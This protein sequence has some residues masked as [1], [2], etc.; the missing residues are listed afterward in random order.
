MQYAG[1]F[2]TFAM[3]F[4]LLTITTGMVRFVTGAPEHYQLNHNAWR[5]CAWCEMILLVVLM[6]IKQQN[7]EFLYGVI[8]DGV[9]GM[10]FLVI[11]IIS[12][13]GEYS[14]RMKS[15]RQT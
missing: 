7:R 6:F 5:F 8:G 4:L 14:Y 2:T 15:W 10:I 9:V 3:V 12:I 11:A 13:F 1:F